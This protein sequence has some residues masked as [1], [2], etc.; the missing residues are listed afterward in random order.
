[1]QVL[2]L[3]QHDQHPKAGSSQASRKESLKKPTRSDSEDEDDDEPDHAAQNSAAEVVR[4]AALAAAERKGQQEAW[5]VVQQLELTC[6]ER[7][8]AFVNKGTGK[9]VAPLPDR[10]EVKWARGGSRSA[11]CGNRPDLSGDRFALAQTARGQCW[12]CLS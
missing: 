3:V 6:C 10:L 1:M 8:V 4:A 2:R 9:L 5:Q 12:T 11:P 7:L